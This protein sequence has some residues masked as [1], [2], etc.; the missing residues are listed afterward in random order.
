MDQGISICIEVIPCL[1]ASAVIEAL[2]T[3]PGFFFGY[4]FSGLLWCFCQSPRICRSLGITL[5]ESGYLLFVL[6][7]KP[8]PF[9]IV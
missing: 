8:L 1:F 5:S 3:M 2:A 9:K 7:G 4:Y 6:P